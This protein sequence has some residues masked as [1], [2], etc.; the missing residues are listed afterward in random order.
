MI[1]SVKG[2]L[3]I[4]ENHITETETF[5]VNIDTPVVTCLRQGSER[6]LDNWLINHLQLD[7]CIDGHR[8][9]AT[10]GITDIGH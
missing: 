4:N 1:Y 2:L 8:N 10:A 9:L 3:Y 7:N 6:I 5:F